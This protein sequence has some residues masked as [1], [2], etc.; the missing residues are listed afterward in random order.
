MSNKIALLAACGAA[1]G[2]SGA[3]RAQTVINISGATLFQNFFLAPASTN[4]FIDVDGDGFSRTGTPPA[5]DQ[6]APYVVP[7]AGQVSGLNGS[8]WEINYR[9]TGSVTGLQELFNYG[10]TFVTDPD[11]GPAMAASLANPRLLNRTAYNPP[12]AGAYNA[13]NPGGCP[14]RSDTT[15]L[16]ATYSAGAAPGGLRVDM[17]VSDVPTLW[18][19][20]VAGT[21]SYVATPG[22]TGYGTNPRI[23][24]DA[25]GHPTGFAQTLATLGTRNLNTG[26]PDS[27][28]VFDTQI[29]VVPIGIITNLG[30]GVRQMTQSELRFFYA[31]G[32][33]LNGENLVAATREPGSGTRNGC[34]NSLGLDPSFGV[35]DSAGGSGTQPSG[36]TT[37]AQTNENRAGP[38][39]LPSNKLGSGDMESTV[40]NNRLAIGYSGAERG[41]NNTWITAGKV[42]FVAVNNDLAGGTPGV[43]VRPTLNNLLHN[44]ADGY[45]ISGSEQ[46]ATLGDA[47]NHNEIGGDAANNHPRMLNAQA[48][49]YLNNITRSIEAFSSAPTGLPAEFSPGEYLASNFILVSAAD[50]VHNFSSPLTWIA[51]PALNS[52][53]QTFVSTDPNNG[54]NINNTAYSTFG[55]VTLNGIVPTRQSSPAVDYRDGVPPGSTYYLTQG[56][57]QLAYGAT[58][59]GGV[60][61]RNRIAGD[62]NGDGV[63]DLNDATEM[64]RAYLQRNGGPTWVAPNGTGP[65]AGAPGSDA[66]IEILGDFNGDGVFDAKDI[67]YWADGLA[68]DPATGK[69]DRKKGYKAI[70]DAWQ[71]LTGNNNFFGTTIAGGRPYHNGDS[72]MDVAGSGGI[73]RGWAPVGADGVIDAQDVAYISAQFIGNPAVTDGHANWDNLNEAIAFD[74]SCDVTGDL[75]VDQADLDAINALLGTCYANCDGSTTVPILTVND[76]ICFQGRF[77]AGD[78]YANC[79]GS[80]TVPTLTVNDFI[81]FQSAFAAG[82]P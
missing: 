71:A 3:A 80:T 5:I 15:T 82:C 13:L 70:D 79:D 68:I 74:L 35:G 76:F 37:T 32:R 46:F 54:Y 31:T 65:I 9:G 17:G 60:H 61:D 57:T 66:C 1:V 77:A 36:G 55:T 20:Q 4:D 2:L 50:R 23:A 52:S 22:S 34:M 16:Q 19:V 64:L 24:T 12:S 10:S 41:F 72:V 6:L 18:G 56:G 69:L 29:A 43:F 47:R 38:A 25:A 73:A 81:C 58:G 51:N 49:A 48:A 63:R 39:F 7:P 30:T 40:F 75:I 27:N 11:S 14:I 45:L 8:W 42:E 44:G 33:R 28:T 26:S 59:G 78:S 62:F 21:T 53:L 67:R